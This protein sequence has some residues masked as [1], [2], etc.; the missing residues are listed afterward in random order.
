MKSTP[1]NNDAPSNKLLL[2][3]TV[4][5]AYIGLT[6]PKS[7]DNVGAV[8]RAAGCY[9]ASEVLYTGVRFDKAMSGGQKTSYRY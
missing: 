3:N 1:P 7:P 9:N 5:H 6:N 2:S 8:M 4:Q